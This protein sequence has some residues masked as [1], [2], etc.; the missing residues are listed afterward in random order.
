MCIVRRLRNRNGFKHPWW[1]IILWT[2]LI[3]SLPVISFGGQYPLWEAGLGAT[4]L[5]MPDYRGSDESR[6]YVFPY[7]YIIYRG[8]ILKI[9]GE[10]I[11]GFLLKT[12]R[13]NLDLSGNGSA[14]VKSNDNNARRGMPD[15]DPTFEVGPSLEVLVSQNKEKTHKI[16]LSL[17]VR[18][19]FS[20]NF[21]QVIYQGWIFSPRLNMEMIKRVP[22]GDWNWGMELGPVWGDQGYHDYYYRVD[23]AFA[24]PGRPAY[25]PQGGYSG[26]EVTTYVG[27]RFNRFKLNLFART[28]FLNGAVFSDSPLVKRN[29]SILAGFAISYLFW[30][31]STMVEADK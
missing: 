21:S 2:L 6:Y 24:I 11:R 19:L 9:D 16:S 31:S 18:A 12:D 3:G 17:P 29:T 8:D 13:L 23:P 26:L 30:T 15:L 1:A 20:T 4:G 14:P 10:D 22:G 27:K 5:T 7:P 28:D 25:S